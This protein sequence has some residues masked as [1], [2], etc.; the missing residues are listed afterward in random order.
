NHR[1]QMETRIFNK[2]DHRLWEALWRWAQR[3]HP[4]KG[5]RW[6]K[7]RY[8]STLDGRDWRFTNKDKIL[9]LLSSFH[10]KPHIKI[11]TDANP[12]LPEHEDYFADR[13][14]RKMRKHLEGRR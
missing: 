12:Y 9:L 1:S 11:R 10:K 2:C 7:K 5:K 13:V 8:F 6:V 4:N 3:R 14:D